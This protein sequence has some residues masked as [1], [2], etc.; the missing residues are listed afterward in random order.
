VSVFPRNDLLGLSQR[1]CPGSK[2]S[3]KGNGKQQEDDNISPLRPYVS[4][5]WIGIFH[6]AYRLALGIQPNWGL[7]RIGHQAVTWGN[8]LLFNPMD[9]F[10]PFSPSDIE[11]DYKIG[12][13]FP[14]ICAQPEERFPTALRPPQGFSQQERYA[15]PIISG[16]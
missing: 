5:K 1:R 16:R 11:R 6:P 2:D 13:G 8:G 12:A 4:V 3:H 14:A 10:N 15:E 7:I 9:L